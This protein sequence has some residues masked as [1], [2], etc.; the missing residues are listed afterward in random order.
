MKPRADASDPG[1]DHIGGVK[2]CGFDGG[3]GGV[4][5]SFHG[6]AKDSLPVGFGRSIDEVVG[7]SLDI[8]YLRSN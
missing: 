8:E 5:H 3:G 2:M 7:R 6:S 4:R 1:M